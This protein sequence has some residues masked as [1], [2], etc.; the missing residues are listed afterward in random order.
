[1]SRATTRSA[2]PCRSSR[3]SA[4][5]SSGR[6]SCAINAHPALHPAGAEPSSSRPWSRTGRR[7]RARSW[8]RCRS[9][10][11]RWSRRRSAASLLA[12]L[13]AQ[14]RLARA[15]VLSVRRH[16]AG[17]AGRRDRAAAAGLSHARACGAG[18]RLP[19]RV[20]PDPRQHH[21]RPVVGRPQPASTCSSM[22]RASRVAAVAAGC[23]SR[24]RCPISSAAC[25]SAAASR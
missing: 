14:S 11:R 21:A 6:R 23:D 16:P 4:R 8:S 13:F 17:D 25:G 18:L 12:L 5:C 10:S 9:R 24:R 20:L 22:Y 7:C 1:M 15:R 2:T 19:G 3:S